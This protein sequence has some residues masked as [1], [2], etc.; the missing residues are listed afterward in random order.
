MYFV[1]N[2][3]LQYENVLSYRT[4]ISE[5]SMPELIQFVCENISSM[6][7]LITG[8]IIFTI[9]ERITDA[10]NSTAILGVEFIIPVDWRFKSSSKYVFKPEFRLVNAVMYKYSG[11]IRNLSKERIKLYE[12]ILR[13]GFKPVTEVYYCVREHDGVSGVICM[14]IGISCN[15]L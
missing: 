4:R 13:R 1:E 15:L 2:Q 10:D 3:Q 7:L 6:D 8:D 14:Y 9:S 11:D 12:Y 5:G